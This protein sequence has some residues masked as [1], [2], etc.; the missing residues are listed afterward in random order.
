MTTLLVLVTV[1]SVALATGLAILLA[2]LLREDR[3]RSDA[4]VAALAEMALEPGVLDQDLAPA[5]LETEN[6]PF[7]DLSAGALQTDAILDPVLRLD[8]QT[9]AADDGL[10]ATRDEPSP[11]GRRVAVAGAL[12][13]VLAAAVLVGTAG[14]VHRDA[15]VAGAPATATTKP[16]ELLALHHSR[17]AEGLTI[18]GLVKN[19]AA[20]APVLRV[21]ATAYVFGPDGTFLTS[22]R[23]PLDS[24]AL[25]AGDQSSFVIKVPVNGDVARY[26]VGFRTDDGTVV[27]H[28]DKRKP[29]TL[30]STQQ[31]QP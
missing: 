26:R 23:A 4:R 3:E 15:T 7:G 9:L 8:R 28:V 17:D 16:I 10:F 18:S 6:R 24:A 5:V 11:W 13:G 12:A 14:R 19:P 27:S 1:V 22:A 31:E 25:P 21:V 2:R 20:G 30:A 29:D